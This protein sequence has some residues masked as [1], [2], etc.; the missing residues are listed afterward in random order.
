MSNF[1]TIET[2]DKFLKHGYYT[3]SNCGGYLVELSD[4]GDSARLQTPENNKV[5]DWFEIEYVVDE[6]DKEGDLIP[7]IDPDGFNISLD[8]VM[9]IN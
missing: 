2:G 1:K 4:C 3:V 8:L 7:V 5:S 6:D 9:R